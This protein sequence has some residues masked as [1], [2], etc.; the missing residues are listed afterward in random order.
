MMARGW[1]ERGR[2]LASAAAFAAWLACLAWLA[3][4]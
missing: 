3:W 1:G 4:R 2:F